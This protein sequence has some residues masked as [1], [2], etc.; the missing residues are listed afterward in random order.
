MPNLNPLVVGL[1]E[2]GAGMFVP[3]TIATFLGKLIE[4]II[5]DQ[6]EIQQDIGLI[7][8]RIDHLERKVTTLHQRQDIFEDRLNQLIVQPF[9]NAHI[10]LEKAKNTSEKK[11]RRR[12]IEQAQNHFL[13]AKEIDAN[14]SV[15]IVPLYR[16]IY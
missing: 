2:L 3:S 9:Q 15:P 16:N 12:Y 14:I 11:E 10:F 1:V 6:K 13:I 5:S 8:S 7:Y 4:T